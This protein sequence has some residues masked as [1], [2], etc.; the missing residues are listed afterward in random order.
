[1]STQLQVFRAKPNP[2]GNDKTTGG[3]P[4]P[5]QLLGEWVD[6][7]NIGTESVPFSRM[8][9]SHALYGSR[10][11]VTGRREAYWTGSG[12]SSLE[13]GRVIRIYTGQKAHES[14]MSP[15]DRGEVEWR[16][17]AERSNFVLNNQC[18][19]VISI[20]WHDGR[21]NRYS[22]TVSY[23]ANQPEGAIL[24]RVGTE[25]VSGMSAGR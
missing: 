25:L 11:E 7:N 16:A 3:V 6:I 8:E 21:G 23:R 14:L 22:D 12:A 9:L 24:T 13:P 10:C 1:M 20:A 15:V 2:I 19:D 18:G 4:K 17:F 5:E